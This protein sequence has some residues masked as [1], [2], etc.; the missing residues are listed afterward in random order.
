MRIKI[1]GKE[2]AVDKKK[3]ISELVSGKGFVPE[4]IVVEHNL[5]I[6]PKEEWSRVTLNEDDIVEIVSFVGGG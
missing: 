6:V 1:N 3:N 5:R 4:H 2:E